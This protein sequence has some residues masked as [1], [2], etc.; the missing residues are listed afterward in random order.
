MTG[1]KNVAEY[2]PLLETALT[3]ERTTFTIFFP[4]DHGIMLTTSILLMV[5][6]FPVKQSALA[7][8]NNTY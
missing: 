6:S 8:P 4:G 5:K 3:F 1:L 2:F 7:L